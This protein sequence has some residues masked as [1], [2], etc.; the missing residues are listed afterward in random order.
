MDNGDG[1]AVGW[2]GHSV[3]RDSFL[4]AVMPTFFETFPV[5]LVD[6]DG[7]V[8]TDVPFRRAESKYSVEQVGVTIEFYGGE[9]NGRANT[10]VI[11]KKPSQG[12]DSISYLAKIQEIPSPSIQNLSDLACLKDAG[13]GEQ[14]FWSLFF[15]LSICDEA[16]PVSEGLHLLSLEGDEAIGEEEEE[17]A[18]DVSLK[19]KS[20]VLEEPRK[21]R[22]PATGKGKD[23]VTLDVPP[24]S[25]FPFQSLKPQQQLTVMVPENAFTIDH[26]VIV[27]ALAR[28]VILPKDRKVYTQLGFEYSF[29]RRITHVSE[30]KGKEEEAS[31]GKKVKRTKTQVMRDIIE[32]H[33]EAIK[34]AGGIECF[35]K[36]PSDIGM[37]SSGSVSACNMAAD[38]NESEKSA[39]G[40]TEPG[41]G[42]SHSYK[43]QLHYDNEIIYKS[44]GEMPP[45]DRLSLNDSRSSHQRQRCESLG[46]RKA[47]EDRRRGSDRESR[48]RHE[49]E[50]SS[51]SPECYRSHG[52]SHERHRHRR[53][54]DDENLARSKYDE[55][56]RSS[57][58]RS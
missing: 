39:F 35:G 58:H 5:V 17:A 40:L 47:L 6:G 32:E 36:G 50:Y 21:K 20:A 57:S 1:I 23:L 51:R 30:L 9:F 54:R 2:L 26:S 7:I 34:Q 3:F 4:Y 44:S 41:R 11:N 38:V 37:L 28:V 25:T 29:N 48:D 13:L 43:K 45:N 53:E 16:T 19:R 8:R 10:D 12:Y 22:K 55:S 14:T 42:H 27:E 33:M 49:R 56:R 46:Y 15:R 18:S 24:S 52:Q 31:R